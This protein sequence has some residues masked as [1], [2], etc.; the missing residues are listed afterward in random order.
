MGEL[1]NGGSLYVTRPVL[2]HYTL[3]REELEWRASD[4]LNWVNSGQINVRIGGTWPLAEAAAAQAALESRAT[5]G[6]LLL[7]P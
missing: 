1:S 3:T 2:S 5:T 4:V 6:K 7:L